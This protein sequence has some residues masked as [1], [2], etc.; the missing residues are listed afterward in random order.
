MVERRGDAYVAGGILLQGGL[1]LYR[2]TS[3]RFGASAF[4]SWRDSVPG[5]EFNQRGTVSKLTEG[6]RG[7]IDMTRLVAI[8]VLATLALPGG[9]Q[10][11]TGRVAELRRSLDTE[12]RR[13]ESESRAW[14]AGQKA[15]RALHEGISGLAD[16]GPTGSVLD[17]L[18]ALLSTE[19]FRFALESPRLPEPDTALSLKQWWADGGYDWLA[20]YLQL[21][22]LGLSTDLKK[23]VVV[24]PDTRRTLRI[25]TGSAHLAPLLCALNDPTCGADTQGWRTRAESFLVLHRTREEQQAR[26]SGVRKDLATQYGTCEEIAAR[27]SPALRYR[28]WRD[29]LESRRSERW[30]LPLGRLKA[31]ASGWLIV[32]GRRGH[33]SFCEAIGAYH[34]GTGAAYIAESCSDLVLDAAGGVDRRATRRSARSRM[35]TGTLRLDNLREV[36][37]ALLLF[38]EAD[39]VQA[40]GEVHPLPS[41]LTPVLSPKE[42]EGSTVFSGGEWA[43]TSQTILE[44]SWRPE[45]GPVATGELTWPDSSNGVEEHAAGLL[46]VAE[47]TLIEG[48]PPSPPP[49]LDLVRKRI[50]VHQADA[51]PG[52]NT[53]LVE[54]FRTW[55]A[56][57]P[58]NP[59]GK[60]AT[61]KAR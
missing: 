44:W 52:I 8:L 49:P 33:Y 36:A 12:T 20:S 10:G 31:P 58:C 16:D 2:G 5:T 6:W 26:E 21:P 22:E 11:I 34:L 47:R 35:R 28:A 59:G 51:V 13:C 56:V 24:P 29:C 1:C 43:S 18:A 38:K 53:Q 41:D 7:L 54:H 55:R 45:S 3:S 50:R 4:R 57:P 30:T 27:A 42:S 48:C 25:G 14:V 46:D 15:L 37:W 17:Q 60:S 23:H 39:K 40:E 19:C 61:A 9:G 32:S